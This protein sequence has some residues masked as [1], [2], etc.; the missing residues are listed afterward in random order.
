MPQLTPGVRRKAKDTLTGYLF[1]SPSIILMLVLLFVPMAYSIYLS[2]FDTSLT[3][4]EP[5]F[6]GLKGYLRIF[7]VRGRGHR[8]EELLSLDLRVAFMQF[9]LDSGPP[10]FST[11]TSVCAGSC[12]VSSSF[13]GVIPG[14]WRR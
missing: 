3:N 7:S 13:P 9:A 8:D 10:S 4:P 5:I 11:G 12:A 14:S 6:L 1:T 2:L